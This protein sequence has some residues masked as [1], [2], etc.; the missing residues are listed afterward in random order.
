MDMERLIMLG[1][2][3]AAVTK[4]Y[5]T[6]FALQDDEDYFLVDT[7][8]GNG[9]LSQLEKAGIPLRK[10]H[11]IFISHE[12]TDH[13]LGIVWM[14]RMVAAEMKKDAYE[15]ELHI[16]CHSDLVDTI[17]TI[18]KLTVQ[19]KFFDLVGKRIFIHPLQHEDNVRILDYEVT[20]FDICSDKAKQYGFTLLLKS[21]KKLTFIGDEYYR[22]SEYSY[23]YRADWLLHEAFCLYR[24]R[25]I[26]KPYEKFHA[27]VKE[28]CENGTMLE[29]KNLV[30]Y[31]TEDK[32][33]TQRKVLYTEEGKDY[34]AGPLYVPDDLDV[35][36]L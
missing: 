16:Y 36:E 27:T 31:H 9:I 34:F 10:I 2:G 14:I 13:L 23:A 3:N 32:N 5:N 18:S 22:E 11:N 35:I 4:C 1:T 29:V 15:G 6:C 28:A 26:F 19:K 33:L 8:G 25:E 20:F 12:H 24:D 17:L 21:G 30:L 7:G